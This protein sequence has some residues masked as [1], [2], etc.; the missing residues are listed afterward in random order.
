MKVNICAKGDK[1]MNISNNEEIF[2]THVK[3]ICMPICDRVISTDISNDFT[4]PDYSP[5]IRRILNVSSSVIPPAKY[6]NTSSAEYNGNID[7]NILYVGSDGELYSIPL[8]AEYNFNVPID[9][10]GFDFNEGVTSCVDMTIDNLT[11][12]LSGPRRLNIKCKMRAHS[13]IYGIYMLDE[14]INGKVKGNSIET[15]EERCENVNIVRANGELL[16]LSEEIIPENPNIRVVGAEG[17]VLISSVSPSK[18]VAKVDGHVYLKLLCAD[19]DVG[20]IYNSIYKRIPFSHSVEL[21]GISANGCCYAIGYINDLSISMEEERIICDLS[22]LIE[23]EGQ[24]PNTFEYVKDMYSTENE[25]TSLFRDYT[26][27]SSGYCVNRNF[28]M[29]ERIAKENLSIPLPF[30]VIQLNNTIKLQY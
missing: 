20:G 6:I 10:D 29:N 23:V 11:T 21:D 25:S 16:Q 19:N 1:F 28:S 18:D 8:N 3:R 24:T 17:K 2:E 27:P 9:A 7:Y 15:L 30:S 22:L 5:E 13:R 26:V 14:K 4:L 12:R